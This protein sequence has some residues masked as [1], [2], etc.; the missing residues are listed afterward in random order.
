MRIND[1]IQQL[2]HALGM[3]KAG[4]YAGAFAAFKSLEQRSAHPRDAAVLCFFQATC[5]TDM[6]KPED[7]LALLSRVNKNELIFS[8]RADYEYEKA[9]I[10][11]ALGRSRRALDI[12]NNAINKLD[13]SDSKQ[14]VSTVLSNMTTLRGIILAEAGSC[15]EAILI[16]EKVPAQD[17][18]WAEAKLHEGDCKY[19]QKLYREAIKCYLSL[20]SDAENVHPF[21]REAA[22]RNV[23]F[24]YYDLGEYATA[25]AY[26][27][28]VENAY[29]EAPDMKAELFSILA[30]SYSHLG[31]AQEAAKYGNFFRGNSSVQ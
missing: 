3:R 5:L 17:A 15:D 25:A 14:T 27:K 28:K 8:Q 21:H 22:I 13:Q 9:R 18:G 16:L 30:S 4:N 23:G 31:M 7:A 6:G 2:D 19:K 20:I 10:E 12:L 29:D 26:L 1:F 24:A 11:R